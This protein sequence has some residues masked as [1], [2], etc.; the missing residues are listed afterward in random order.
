M[1]VLVFGVN[2]MTGRAVAAAL[3]AAGWQVAGAGRSAE[4]FP[5]A[6]RELGVAFVPA[7]RDDAKTVHTAVGGGF[8]VVIDAVA[9]TAAHARSLLAASGDI[10]SIV[11]VSSKAVYVDAEGRHSNTDEPPD[12]GGPVAEDTATMAPDFSGDYMSRLGY[13]SNKAAMEAVYRSADVPVTLLRP[14]RIHGPGNAWP[15]EEWVVRR[16]LEGQRLFRLPHA[17]TA[18]NHPTAAANLARLVVTCAERPAHRILNSADPG[19]PTAADVVRAIADTLDRPVEIVD[20]PAADPSP[21]ST[22]PPFFLDTRASEAL[23]Y[24]PVGDYAT[25]V[26]AAVDDVLARG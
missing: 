18:G 8:D 4:R 2:G 6:L 22:D 7:D 12:F 23:G 16:L 17:S 24:R 3:A 26:R 5:L 15:R 19:T 11:A 25:T 13:G 9:Y 21:W 1:R 10:G 14:S 20:D